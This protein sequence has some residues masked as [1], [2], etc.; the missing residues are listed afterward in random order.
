MAPSPGARG[1]SIL[2]IWLFFASLT[3][4]VSLV[5]GYR[6]SVAAKAPQYL[7]TKS[8]VIVEE[9]RVAANAIE[10][11]LEA[12]QDDPEFATV[13]VAR[14]MLVLGLLDGALPLVLVSG[15]IARAVAFFRRRIASHRPYPVR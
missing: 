13:P 14:P 11:Q 5:T 9:P 8:T 10:A 4:I 7:F 15:L 1:V 12:G 6:A 2:A 3:L